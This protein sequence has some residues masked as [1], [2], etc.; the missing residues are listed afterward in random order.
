MGNGDNW[1]EVTAT[2]EFPD[3]LAGKDSPCSRACEVLGDKLRDPDMYCNNNS[4]LFQRISGCQEAIDSLTAN[5]PAWCDAP[6]EQT[7]VFASKKMT[8]REHIIAKLPAVQRK[9]HEVS[10]PKAST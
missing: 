2:F 5:R 7:V 9:L 10:H 1:D 6:A 4:I 8:K 3:S